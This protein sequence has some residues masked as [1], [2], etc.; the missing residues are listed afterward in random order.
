MIQ[1]GNLWIRF[2][3]KSLI[4]FSLSLPNLPNPFSLTMV[5]A[6]TQLPT[7]MSIR[8]YFRGVQRGRRKRMT[9]SPL[10]VRQLSIKHGKLN[11]SQPYRPPRPVARIALPFLR[12]MLST[13]ISK[14]FRVHSVQLTYGLAVDQVATLRTEP[15]NKAH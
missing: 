12:V 8:K 6:L 7:K 4:F 14:S 9:T 2:L 13:Q 15:S 1:A 5:L 10:S 11:V 3:M